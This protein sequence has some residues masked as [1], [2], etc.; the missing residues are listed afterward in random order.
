MTGKGSG[1]NDALPNP[2][3]YWANRTAGWS[4]GASDGAAT[5]DTFDRALIEASAIIPGM[6]VL[7]LAAGSGD[8]SVTIATH[9]A[10]NG[11]VTACDMTY[12]MLAMAQARVDKLALANFRIVSGDM[13]ALPFPDACFDAV[14]CRNGLMFPADK[15]ACVAEARRVLRPGSKGA[16][17][18]WSTIDDNPTFLTVANGLRRYFGEDFP[19]RMIRHSLGEAGSLSALLTEAGFQDVTERRFAYERTVPIGDDYFRCAAARTIPQRV[20]SLTEKDWSDLLSTIEEASAALRDGD[21][22]RIPI[23]ARLAAGTAPT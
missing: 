1:P 11:T 14:T 2:K 19:P 16:W 10:G 17:L 12:D 13:A 8:P 20:A 4:A 5:D 15:L 9:L 6:D 7:D 23:V 3:D 22:F 21:V 18:V